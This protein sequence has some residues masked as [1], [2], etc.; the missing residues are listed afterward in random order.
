MKLRED[1][2]LEDYALF[3]ILSK[4][5]QHVIFVWD[6]DHRCRIIDAVSGNRQV[7]RQSDDDKQM[8]M[9]NNQIFAMYIK[10]NDILSR[11]TL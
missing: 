7:E 1:K 10:F 2:C 5:S 4:Y 6:V 8:Y 3:W 11:F 9:E